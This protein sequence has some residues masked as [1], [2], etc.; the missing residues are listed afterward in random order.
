[1]RHVT[2][3]CCDDMGLLWFVGSLKKQASCAKEPYKRDDILQNRLIFSRSLLSSV[4]HECVDE[5]CFTWKWVD[6]SCLT[7]DWVMSHVWLSYRVMSHIW[8]SH[9]TYEW[10]HVA[11]EWVTSHIWMSHVS[12]MIELSSPVA[13]RTE[14]TSHI[15]ES[16][17][18]N[19]WVMSHISMSPWAHHRHLS[20]TLSLS[21]THT[22][23]TAQAHKHL[24]VIDI[25]DLLGFFGKGKGFLSWHTSNMM[26]YS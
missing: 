22:Q 5:L 3:E 12:R 10:V 8:L 4:T 14:S 1:M 2:Y 17:R 20:L 15:N 9:V 23:H 21:R 25:D 16:R 24:V 11:Y 13:C 26:S 18:T 7:Y 19:K 6:E